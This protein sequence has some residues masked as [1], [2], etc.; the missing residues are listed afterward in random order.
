MSVAEDEH[1]AAH[2]GR[3]PLPRW[4]CG[5]SARIGWSALS[6]VKY[7]IAIGVPNSEMRNATNAATK[8]A[9]T[10]RRLGPEGVDD[11]PRP[12]PGSL[13][14]DHVAGPQLGA[15]QR[16]GGLLIGHEH[17]VSSPTRH[18][19]RTVQDRRGLLAHGHETVD[20][21]LRGETTDLLM[22]GSLDTRRAPP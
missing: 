13:D 4:P 16:D 22:S 8:T 21:E 15:Q 19:G 5:P 11:V 7:L 14:Q 12:V 1:H 18:D 3:A 9:L 2:R 17:R 20:A 6:R 10:S